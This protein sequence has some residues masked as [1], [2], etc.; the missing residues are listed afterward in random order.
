MY[1]MAD[2]VLTYS[3][4]CWLLATGYW[5][6]APNMQPAAILRVTGVSR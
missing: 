2:K 3:L 4:G 1:V 5:L 6:L